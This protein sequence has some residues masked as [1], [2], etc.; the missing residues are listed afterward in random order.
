MLVDRFSIK[1][2]ISP[3]L[4]GGPHDINVTWTSLFNPAGSNY[5]SF[6]DAAV[7]MTRTLTVQLVRN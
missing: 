3:F 5:L 2:G 7:N 1:E 6:S 4:P